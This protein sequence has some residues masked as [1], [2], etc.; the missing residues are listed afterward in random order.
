LIKQGALYWD[1]YSY[2]QWKIKKTGNQ[3][4]RSCFS[5]TSWRNRHTSFYVTDNVSRHNTQ[6][7]M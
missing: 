2:K 6:N 7:E 1:F 3:N 4:F 5:C